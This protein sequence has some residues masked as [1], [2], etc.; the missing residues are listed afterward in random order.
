VNRALA[1]VA[2]T[3]LGVVLLAALVRDESWYQ[4]KW[5]NDA[6]PG[7]GAAAGEPGTLVFATDRH[8][9]WLLWKFPE[10]RGRVAYDVR[11]EIYDE[12]FFEDLAEYKGQ[13][14]DWKALARGY[15]LV[16]VDERSSPDHTAAFLAEPGARALYRDD[17]IA[18]VR[19]PVTR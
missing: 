12:Q 10:L 16:V 14:R 6:L 3:A 8:A 15:E 17:V 7:V 19:R 18:V 5:P 1:A 9:D 4:R 13:T 2:A 11:F